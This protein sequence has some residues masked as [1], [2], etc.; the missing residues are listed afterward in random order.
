MATDKPRPR[1]IA[2][3]RQLLPT[4]RDVV[5]L[6]HGRFLRVIENAMASGS[7][8]MTIFV[9]HRMSNCKVQGI[10]ARSAKLWEENVSGTVK[11]SHPDPY[12]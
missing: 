2:T 7:L 10:A 9:I 11:T 8:A 3:Q 5:W 1:A 6:E 12:A 4:H